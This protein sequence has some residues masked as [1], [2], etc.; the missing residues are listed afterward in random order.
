M[1]S[2]DGRLNSKSDWWLIAE[3]GV[4]HENSMETAKQ[5]IRQ[6]AENG[7]HAAKFQTYKAGKLAIRDSP[8]YWDTTKEPAQNQ[9]ELFSR[10]DTFGQKEYEELASYCSEQN[11]EFM[12]T[13]FDIESLEYIDNLV[14]IHKIASADVTNTPLIRAVAKKG[15]PV[16][17]STGAASDEEIANAIQELHNHGALEVTLLHCVL[18]YPTPDENAFLGRI[19]ELMKSHPNSGIGYSD[20]TVPDGECMACIAAYNLGARIFEKHFT[21]DKSLSGNDHYHAMDAAD[22]AQLSYRLNQMATMTNQPT[23][24]EFLTSQSAA[25]THARRSIVLNQAVKAGEALTESNLTTK[26]PASGLSPLHW[27][28]II[29]RKAKRDLPEDHQISFEDVE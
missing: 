14:N 2:L 12:S 28:E 13:A 6:C 19:S 29:G 15:K 20:H 11:I 8:A 23:E 1:S 26:R 7:A 9:F 10:F 24:A 5:M 18:N 17:M 27:D 3:I 4:N 22:L 21:H 16:L 25:I